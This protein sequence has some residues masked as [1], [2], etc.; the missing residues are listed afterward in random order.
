MPSAGL[1]NR[2]PRNRG[3]A[4]LHLRKHGTGVEEIRILSERKSCQCSSLHDQ[5]FSVTDLS[6]VISSLRTASYWRWHFAQLLRKLSLFNT[7]IVLL[8]PTIRSFVKGVFLVFQIADFTGKLTN[9]LPKIW[10]VRR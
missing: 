6:F 9:N 8:L 1:K 3:A 7:L 2:D 5:N 4:D 10:N